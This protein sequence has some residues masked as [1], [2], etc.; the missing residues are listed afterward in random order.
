MC[1]EDPYADF[2]KIFERFA[3][4]EQV[5]GLEPYKDGEDSAE[6]RAACFCVDLARLARSGSLW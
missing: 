3:T 5:T 1:Q 6:V 2:K 4:A